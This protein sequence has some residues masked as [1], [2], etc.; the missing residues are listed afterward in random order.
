MCD[1][2]AVISP[3]LLSALINR[4]TVNIRLNS[5]FCYTLSGSIAG[6]RRLKYP[7]FFQLM[8]NH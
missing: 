2:F 4:Y 6:H 8:I 3:H 5:L 1:S 7:N